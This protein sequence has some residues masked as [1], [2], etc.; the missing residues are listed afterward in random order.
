MQI[1]R[2]A[3]DSLLWA[4]MCFSFLVKRIQMG[5]APS[6]L[7]LFEKCCVQNWSVNFWSNPKGYDPSSLGYKRVVRGFSLVFLMQLQQ[8]NSS[9]WLWWNTTSVQWKN[10][11]VPMH[12]PL[13]F[14][15]SK[16]FISKLALVCVCV[17]VCVH[18][19]ARVC[20]CVCVCV[21]SSD[22]AVSSSFLAG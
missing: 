1:G 5:P 18:A 14:L 9:A 17:C 11:S 22:P 2:L 12:Q 13:T 15:C 21:F 19:R 16:H 4:R 20:V 3:T 8:Q 10:S 6:P 7:L